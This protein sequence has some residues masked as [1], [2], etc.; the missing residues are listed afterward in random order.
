MSTGMS[1]LLAPAVSTLD[2]FAVVAL[3]V[4]ALDG[5]AARCR[6]L[7]ARLRTLVHEAVRALG[8]D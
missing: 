7:I 4:T 1:H 8:V 5:V 6:D 3:V 2:R